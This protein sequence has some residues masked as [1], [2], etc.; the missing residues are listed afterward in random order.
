MEYNFVIQ[1]YRQEAYTAAT[2]M[3]LLTD[4]KPFVRRRKTSDARRRH[5]IHDKGPP[6]DPPR[7]LHA[8]SDFN[9]YRSRM[10]GG[11]MYRNVLCRRVFIQPLL[12]Y[13]YTV[14]LYFTRVGTYNRHMRCRYN[15]YH[16]SKWSER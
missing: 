11:A 4:V 10:T 14:R 2:E 9:Y 15:Q 13:V 16:T 12:A 3:T 7:L 1:S 6:A 5:H 8:R